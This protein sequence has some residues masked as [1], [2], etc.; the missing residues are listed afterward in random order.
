MSLG[1]SLIKANKASQDLPKLLHTL[2]FTSE[3][4][5]MSVLVKN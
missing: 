4:K 3:R 2:H 1:Y 5:L